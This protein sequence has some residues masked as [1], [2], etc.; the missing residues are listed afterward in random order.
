MLQFVTVTKL[1][2]RRVTQLLCPQNCI[3]IWFFAELMDIKPLKLHAKS[4]S[5]IEFDT[6]KDSEVLYTLTIKQLY[7]YLANRQL[8][9]KREIDVFQTGMK[10]WYKNTC[11]RSESHTEDTNIKILLCILSCVNFNS[12]SDREIKEM[13]IHP[14]LVNETKIVAILSNI[15]DIRNNVIKVNTEEANTEDFAIANRLCGARSRC[16]K[17]RP[18]ILL[19]HVSNQKARK[20]E[21]NFHDTSIV[22]YGEYYFINVYKYFV[23][24]HDVSIYN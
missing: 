5:L 22:Y 8:Q 9:C 16:I 23:P 18:C 3:K 7:Y 20:G 1:C 10:W 17:K 14:G 2:I 6:I 15:L 12:V 24:I 13:L 21:E 19:N 4:M 11:K